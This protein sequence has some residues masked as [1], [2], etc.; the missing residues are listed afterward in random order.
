ME[1]FMK[2][3]NVSLPMSA[4]ISVLLL[5][6]ALS[7]QSKSDESQ[8]GQWRVMGQDLDNSR[9]QPEPAGRTLN[10]SRQRQGP[11]PKMGVYNQQRF[12]R[13]L[14]WMVTQFTSPIGAA[15]STPSRRTVA[16]SSGLARSSITTGQRI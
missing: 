12:L 10:H 13:L 8:S 3:R 5:V 9:S 7:A 2:T 6:S 16:V 1:M 11:Q 14:P 4:L 15:I